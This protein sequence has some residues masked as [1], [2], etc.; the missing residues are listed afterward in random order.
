MKKTL[1][2]LLLLLLLFGC[3]FDKLPGK[4]PPPPPLP[5][6]ADFI[7]LS[8]TRL[9]TFRMTPDPTQ[10]ELPV[11]VTFSGSFSDTV[12]FDYE[13]PT[14]ISGGPNNGQ[15]SGSFHWEAETYYTT[16]TNKLSTTVPLSVIFYPS[17]YIASFSGRINYL[18]YGYRNA[19]WRGRYFL[20]TASVTFVR[21]YSNYITNI[22]P[23]YLDYELESFICDS[24]IVPEN[25]Y[26]AD[27]NY[28]RI[29]N[30]RMANIVVSG[31]ITSLEPIE[32]NMPYN[33]QF[34]GWYNIPLTI[35]PFDYTL[36]YRQVSRDFYL[37][38]SISITFDPNI[39]VFGW[40]AHDGNISEIIDRFEFDPDT[41]T[42][43]AY[44]KEYLD[45]TLGDVF[46]FF[47]IAEDG[48]VTTKTIS[49]G[50]GNLN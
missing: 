4:D 35:E 10:L 1:F 50:H 28:F 7:A 39:K 18:E 12:S 44:F 6:D 14:L 8:G 23:D 3:D 40:Q 26:I 5:N 47:I 24:Y 45:N 34:A 32:P 29:H 21:P 11:T 2:P 36:F 17:D 42:L 48:S 16:F 41:N 19:P 33:L 27:K 46:S 13:E 43:T 9:K 37:Y 25:G 20:R 31:E 49:I 22:N 38:R 30:F 15:P